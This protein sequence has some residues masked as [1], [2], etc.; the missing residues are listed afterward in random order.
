MP[1]VSDREVQLT[2]IAAEGEW[3]MWPLLPMKRWRDAEGYQEGVIASGK[4]VVYRT[5]IF[6]IPAG[7]LKDVLPPF[8]KI[9]YTSFESM[10]DDGWRVD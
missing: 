7:M 3:P 4:P 2:R 10:V 8:D 5:N 1:E 6:N 9:E